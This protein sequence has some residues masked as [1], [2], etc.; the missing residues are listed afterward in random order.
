MR[1]FLFDSL[2]FFYKMEDKVICGEW[3]A[4]RPGK[5]WGQRRRYQSIVWEKGENKHARKSSQDGWAVLGAHLKYGIMSLKEVSW[6]PYLPYKS[7]SPPRYLG[8]QWESCHGGALEQGKT[9]NIAFHQGLW[10]IT[11][12]TLPNLSDK[13]YEWALYLLLILSIISFPCLTFH[14]T[15]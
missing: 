11:T 9:V 6:W 15:L 10:K 8:S 13:L 12:A 2:K 3:E 1:G 5:V 14:Q 7:F 4:E